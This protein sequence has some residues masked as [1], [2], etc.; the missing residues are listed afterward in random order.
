M[1]WR[2]CY[3][4]ILHA[5]RSDVFRMRNPW[6]AT[7]EQRAARGDSRL[8]TS[9]QH[10]VAPKFRAKAPDFLPSQFSFPFSSFLLFFFCFCFLTFFRGCDS[11][12]GLKNRVACFGE[13]G[14]FYLRGVVG[15]DSDY[16]TIRP[17]SP[18]SNSTAYTLTTRRSRHCSSKNWTT[19][20]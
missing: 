5:S 1:E 16:S 13:F 9:S 18:W 20:C 8:A 19:A 14:N 2:M 3:A 17:I 7:R 10:C 15:P 12:V 4:E 11:L 6:V